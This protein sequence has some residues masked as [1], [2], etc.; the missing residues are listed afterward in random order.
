MASKNVT[1]VLIGGKIYTLGG[2]ES[3]EYLQRVAAYL[4]A[5]ITEIKTLDG[6][7]RMPAEMK[8]L[9][10]NLNTADDYF[11]LKSQADQLGE[12]ISGKDRELYEIKHELITAQMKMEKMQRELD[13]ARENEK[14]ALKRIAALE[15]EALAEHAEENGAGEADVP[16]PDPDDLLKDIP[17][18]EEA[19]RSYG[20]GQ[21]LTGA[22]EAQD[23]PE[24]NAEE[25]EEAAKD[26]LPAEEEITLPDP[27]HDGGAS[28]A[29]AEQMSLDLE[30]GARPARTSTLKSTPRKKRKRR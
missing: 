30:D 17:A 19:G 3:E 5:K 10:L 28:Y 11:K 4:N 27:F 6:Y 24:D 14:A 12:Q 16:S 26:A 7:A 18:D 29:Q 22:V 9:L 1:Q 21:D 20:P 8:S 23:K 2:Y 25:A 15:A 13:S